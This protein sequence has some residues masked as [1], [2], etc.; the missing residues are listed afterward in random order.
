MYIITDI[1]LIQYYLI[2]INI[3]INNNIFFSN[4]RALSSLYLRNVSIIFYCYTDIKHFDPC[5]NVIIR[6]ANDIT[7]V[8]RSKCFISV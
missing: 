6:V 4:F 5:T 3:D 8:H 2:N 7:F 1:M